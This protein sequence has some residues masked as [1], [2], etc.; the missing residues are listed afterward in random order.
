MYDNILPELKKLR[1]ALDVELKELE[2]KVGENPL[3]EFLELK[4][5]FCRLIEEHGTRSYQV[6]QFVDKNIKK[7]QRLKKLMNWQQ[8]NFVNGLHR[9]TE[10]K[11]KIQ[12]LDLLIRG[13]SNGERN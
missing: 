4:A 12:E 6:Q 13:I 5:Q 2:Y 1:Q 11:S 8:K 10:L 9:I 3:K 7:E